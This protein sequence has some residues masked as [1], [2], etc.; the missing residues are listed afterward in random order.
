MKVRHYLRRPPAVPASDAVRLVAEGAVIVD[1]RRDF[2]WNRVHIPG[3]VHM[4]LEVL[5]E[6]C[7]E[8]PEDRLLIAFCTGG[9]RSAG[10][11]NLL[12]ENGFDATNMS[13]GLIGWRAAG[14]A[15]SE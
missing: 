2:E 11:A 9:I 3:A 4:P 10:A 13:G 1:V 14:G 8:L 5:P 15:L 7:I 12:V 6:R